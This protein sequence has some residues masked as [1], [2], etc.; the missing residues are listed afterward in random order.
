MYKIFINKTLVCLKDQDSAIDNQQYVKFDKLD[1][2]F[3]LEKLNVQSLANVNV[4][5]DNLQEDLLRFISFF[6]IREAAG[7]VVF[8]N[9]NQLLWIK[10]FEMWDL[11]KGHVEENEDKKDAALR[12][13]S[14]ECN[15]NHL[16]IEKELETTYHVYMYQKKLVLKKTYWYL[17]RTEKEDYKLIP[18]TEEDI[19]E[20]CFKSMEDSKFCLEHTYGNI[21]LLLKPIL[22]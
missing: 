15:L 22:L 10:R 5:C 12:E 1:T 9:K 18:Q 8:N 16:T 17:M 3:F 7:G 6:E 20:A 14:E 11:P 13:V 19:T 21:N 2:T 4:I